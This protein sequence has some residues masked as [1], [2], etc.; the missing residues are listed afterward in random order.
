MFRNR[1]VQVKFVKNNNI[2]GVSTDPT[3]TIST[4]QAYAD[5]VIEKKLIKN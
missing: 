1:A 5:I 2:D 4:V 3:E